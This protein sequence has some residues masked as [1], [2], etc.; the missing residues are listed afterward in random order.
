MKEDRGLPSS[1]V[2]PVL[3]FLPFKLRMPATRAMT[4][5]AMLVFA[6]CVDMFSG[7]SGSET[8]N[9]IEVAISE[10]NGDAPAA[11]ARVRL[12]PADYLAAPGAS[13]SAGID[14]VTDAG[15]VIRITGLASGRYRLEVIGAAA[16]AGAA[17]KEFELVG[18]GVLFMGADTLT[19]TGMVK[20]QVEFPGESGRL[21]A[22][23]YGL[24]RLAWV[25]SSGHFEFTDLPAG[26]HSFRVV[27]EVE[28]A[29]ASELRQVNVQSE[30]TA[31]ILLLPGWA[32]ARRLWL[33]T[34]ADG[35]GVSRDVSDFPVL[36]RLDAR[37][38][39]FSQARSDGADL[40]FT[41]PDGMPLA[42][43]IERWDASKRLAEV[44]VL[45]DTV[46]GS[47]RTAID[48]HW[49]NAAAASAHAPHQVFSDAAG[50]ASVWHLNESPAGDAQD[51]MQDRSPSAWHLT[52]QGNQV[53]AGNV[54]G[55][56]GRAIRLDGV[57]DY[58]M[59]LKR[60]DFNA[61]PF[62]FSAWVRTSHTGTQGILA[63]EGQNRLRFMVGHDGRIRSGAFVDKVWSDGA[64]VS[65][66]TDGAWHY[67]A[68]TWDTTGSV[69]IYVDG[70]REG[71]AMVAE[72]VGAVFEPSRLS[73]GYDDFRT[74]SFFRG[75]LDEVRICRQART[76]D[77][78]RLG[79]MNQR[80]S[81]FLLEW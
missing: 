55:R 1:R 39:D 40:R 24:E 54:D 34:T 9:G 37:R 52:P 26:V 46:R 30:D 49:G 51:A 53:R 32:H 45:V 6:G 8:N 76:P 73:L 69:A 61:V 81:D 12:R 20:G 21:F 57:D 17:L 23:V 25:D 14:T 63:K 75:V 78:I 80:E 13:G 38:F 68:V 44:W 11:N 10:R 65:S 35:A 36:V 71:E 15:G 42:H 28:P 48:M 72:S 50:F 5:A 62:T 7:G 27:S 58:L 77:W 43:S 47:A 56:I 3:P 64:S 18:G 59:T 29:R 70:A 66:V 4:L 41:R 31:R 22:Q 60:P 16:G 74:G 19:P 33:N 2:E 79:Y 67:V